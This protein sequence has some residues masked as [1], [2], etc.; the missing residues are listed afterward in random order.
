MER[1]DDGRRAGWRKFRFKRREEKKGGN[2][3][4]REERPDGGEE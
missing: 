4:G 3:G 2:V 1:G